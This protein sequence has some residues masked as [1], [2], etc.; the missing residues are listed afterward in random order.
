MISTAQKQ[1]G[2]WTPDLLGRLEALEQEAASLYGSQESLHV[3]RAL[4]AL[5]NLRMAVEARLAANVGAE[6]REVRVIGY[7]G[8]AV[9]LGELERDRLYAFY[10]VPAE[11]EDANVDVQLGFGGMRVTARRGG[12]VVFEVPEVEAGRVGGT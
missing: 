1:S 7:S 5:S 6:M 2:Y 9:S 10:G 4:R 12:L 3:R 8:E 11:F